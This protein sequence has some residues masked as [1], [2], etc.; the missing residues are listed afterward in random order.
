MYQDVA[1]ARV[2]FGCGAALVQLPCNGVVSAFR[3]SGPELNHWLLGKNALCDYLVS[4][5]V[6]E[7]ESYAKGKPWSRV[8]WDVTT[9]GWLLN[10]EDKLMR[11]CLVASPIPQPDHH[12]SFDPDRHLMRYVYTIHRDALLE[13]LI[14]KLTR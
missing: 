12:Y 2:V 3:M 5:T 14:A 7:A 1:A 8:I 10:D 9:I 13:D 6:E 4:H 11:S